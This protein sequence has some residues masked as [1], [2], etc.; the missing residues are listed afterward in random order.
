MARVVERRRLRGTGGKIAMYLFWG[1]NAV[2]PLSVFGHAYQLAKRGA[3]PS[4]LTLEGIGGNWFYLIWFVG[5]V[6]LGAI[7]MATRGPLVTIERDTEQPEAE[8]RAVLAN[9]ETIPLPS[10]AERNAQGAR[11]SRIVLG[12]IV[13]AL[14]GGIIVASLRN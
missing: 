13:A 6:L 14:V 10:Q 8:A 3:D 4:A 2:M 5:A 12:V 9:G 1:F 11:H 7:M